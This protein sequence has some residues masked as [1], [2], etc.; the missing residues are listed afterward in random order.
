MIGDTG[1]DS[2]T[3]LAEIVAEFLFVFLQFHEQHVL[4]LIFV[5]EFFIHS[6]FLFRTSFRFQKFLDLGIVIHFLNDRLDQLDAAFSPWMATQ[7]LRYTDGKDEFEGEKVMLNKFG[8]LH[9]IDEVLEKF[10]DD[11]FV[12]LHFLLGL[13]NFEESAAILADHYEKLL[14]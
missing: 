9:R 14:Q 10:V 5:L 2:S 3:E 6:V 4:F 12:F 11:F 8:E 7:H 13:P 1:Q